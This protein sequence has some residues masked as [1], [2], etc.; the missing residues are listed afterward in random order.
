MLR[1]HKEEETVICNFALSLYMHVQ[2]ALQQL[3]N[4]W[5]TT[6]VAESWQWVNFQDISRYICM[7]ICFLLLFLNVLG[8]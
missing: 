1:M 6:Y 4:Y 3:C 7:Y 8:S 5:Y 2:A